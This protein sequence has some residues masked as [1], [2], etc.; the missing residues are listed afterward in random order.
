MPAV[1]TGAAGVC[2]MGLPSALDVD[3]G[4]KLPCLVLTGPTCPGIVGAPTT[5]SMELRV[6]PAG[7]LLGYPFPAPLTRESRLGI[8]FFFF[9]NLYLLT[10]LCFRTFYCPVWDYSRLIENSGNLMPCCSSS[11]EA[12]GL[13]AFL[14]SPFRVL[15]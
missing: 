11:L 12:P 14:F 5:P 4:I 3:L 1:P 15:L 8:F 2:G 9:L 7:S 13:S 6:P 10:V